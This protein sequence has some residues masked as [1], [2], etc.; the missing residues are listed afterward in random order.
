MGRSSENTGFARGPW[1]KAED[2]HLRQLVALHQPKNWTVLASKLGTRSGKQC[3][4][5]WLNHLNPF[6]KKGPWSS[7]EDK[8]LI[9]LHHSLGNRWSDIAKSLP[10][11]TDNSIK[12]RYLNRTE[13]EMQQISADP[14]RKLRPDPR[15][16][17]L[18]HRQEHEGKTF[19]MRLTI[20]AILFSLATSICFV[21]LFSLAYRTI[22]I[23][24]FASSC[25][26][27]RK[28]MEAVPRWQIRHSGRL[29]QGQLIFILLLLLNLTIVAMSHP[30]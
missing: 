4:E 17:R 30:T 12:V 22:G 8:T 29:L 5:R 15:R 23:A 3:R 16:E 20:D 26:A 14:G 1:S 13:T 24:R 19:H 28:W 25:T 18:V 9:S 2:A 7:E 6:I 27:M 21:C 10:G 11:R